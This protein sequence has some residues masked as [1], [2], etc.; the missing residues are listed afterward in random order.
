MHNVAITMYGL[1]LLLIGLPASVCLGVTFQDRTATF[2]PSGLGG[3]AAWGD[4]NNS[5]SRRKGSFA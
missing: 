1:V 5:N 3:K 4:Y 2:Y